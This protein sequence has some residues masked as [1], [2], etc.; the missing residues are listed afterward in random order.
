MITT[1]ISEVKTS[2]SKFI[3]RV[4]Y[5]RERIVVTS[6]GQP[7]AALIGIDD[8]RRLETLEEEQE[9]AMLAEAISSETRFY[10]VAEIEAELATLEQGK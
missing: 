6:H 3:N 7:K 9:A 1:S 8:L 2:F 4:S 5:G 10:S